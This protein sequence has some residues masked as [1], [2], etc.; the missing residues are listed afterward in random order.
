MASWKC[1]GA[2]GDDGTEALPGVGVKWAAVGDDGTDALPVV[3][4]TKWAAADVFTGV[5]S[6][7]RCEVGDVVSEVL[8]GVVDG[9]AVANCAVMGEGGV[10]V[11]VSFVCVMFVRVTKCAAVGEDGVE[12]FPVEVVV[13]ERAKCAAAVGEPGAEVL[14][15][16]STSRLGKGSV[17]E[18]GVLD[19]GPLALG[20]EKLNAPSSRPDGDRGHSTWH[21]PPTAV[22]LLLLVATRA[23]G[24]AA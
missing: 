8:P 4:V 18:L 7:K 19:R 22:L 14:L 5:G 2:V 6:R 21:W 11:E 9:I 15:L 17:G 20:L 23:T 1:G 12:V 16:G 3:G 13:G 10:V 24:D